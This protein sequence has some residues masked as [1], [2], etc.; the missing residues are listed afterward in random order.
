MR[1]LLFVGAVLYV[2]VAL[3]LPLTSARNAVSL[4]PNVR[5]SVRYLLHTV[6][7]AAI[8]GREGDCAALSP[9][10]LYEGGPSVDD[11]QAF[12]DAV[13][14]KDAARCG[15]VSAMLTPDLRTFCLRTFASPSV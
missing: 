11:W 5:A 14:S 8:T 15:D 7:A 2:G 9:I 13:T 3:R 1:L 10:P 12:C 4:Y 6:E